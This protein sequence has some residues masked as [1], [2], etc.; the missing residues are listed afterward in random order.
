M[1]S[2][3]PACSGEAGPGHPRA[4]MQ[5]ARHRQELLRRGRRG[6]AMAA[7]T[8]GPISEDPNLR[9]PE[10]ETRAGTA[11]KEAAAPG[12]QGRR[13]TAC[14]PSAHPS[15]S[16]P[17]RQ[18]CSYLL[19]SGPGWVKGSEAA[20]AEVA[21]DGQQVVVYGRPRSAQLIDAIGSIRPCGWSC[22]TFQSSQTLGFSHEKHQLTK[23]HTSAEL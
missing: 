13:K 14:E 20:W 2:G 11:R 21:A 12:T 1:D 17:P 19:A 16:P 6:S 3:C 22:Q 5:N 10:T 23:G 8:E 9:A 15:A 7:S 4:W 18:A